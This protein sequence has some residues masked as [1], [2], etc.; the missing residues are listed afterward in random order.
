MPRKE[1]TSLGRVQ[2]QSTDNSANLVT[3]ARPTRMPVPQRS[4]TP[5]VDQDIV[6][7]QQG[8]GGL[9]DALSRMAASQL[10]KQNKEDYRRGQRDRLAA[11]D[12]ILN[13][14]ETAAGSQTEPYRQGFMFQHGLARSIE[15]GLKLEE[16]YNELSAEG[17][18]TPGQFNKFMQTFMGQALEGADDDY[19]IQGYMDHMIKKEAELRGRHAEDNYT[20]SRLTAL[21]DFNMSLRGTLNSGLS[22]GGSP[23]DIHDTVRSFYDHARV[24]GIPLG[25]VDEMA[26]ESLR[27]LAISHGRTDIFGTSAD[28]MGVFEFET[29]DVDNPDKKMTPLA[30]RTQWQKRIFDAQKQV[31]TALKTKTGKVNQM[32][33]LRE[34][35]SIDAAIEAGDYE[36]AS[37]M[38]VGGVENGLWQADKGHSLLEKVEKMQA[39][40]EMKALIRASVANESLHVAMSI[41]PDITDAKVVEAMDEDF[42]KSFTDAM[43]ANDSVAVQDAISTH[44]QMRATQ[45][46]PFKPAFTQI[47]NASPSNLEGWLTAKSNYDQYKSEF[48]DYARANIDKSKQQQFDMFDWSVKEAGMSPEVAAARL[49]E[50][51]TVE[52]R[53]QMNDF[54]GRHRRTHEA[55][56]EDE[57]IAGAHA[58]WWGR[59]K[60]ATNAVEIKRI[61]TDYAIN[62]LAM[63]GGMSSVDA[64][65]EKAE[66]YVDANYKTVK[67]PGTD[68]YDLQPQNGYPFPEDYQEMVNWASSQLAEKLKGTQYESVGYYFQ[69]D[70]N[71]R[72]RLIARDSE[73]GYGVYDQ[74][75]QPITMERSALRS[76]YYTSQLPTEDQVQLGRLTERKLQTQPTESGLVPGVRTDSKTTRAQAH[77]D[78]IDAIAQHN[79]PK[80]KR[81][82]KRNKGNAL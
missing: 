62:H 57:L 26:F 74:T 44:M 47:N 42:T 30:S 77:R 78:A 48:P 54:F 17:L 51:D 13:D 29:L 43:K 22:A 9:T 49:A 39:E 63:S 2:V 60:D 82:R 65:M 19:F 61:V 71:N 24:V 11:T 79:K 3:P 32:A 56:I 55:R 69:P 59:N 70:P 81:S 6:N 76:G 25:Q 50:L 66:A 1:S 67:R 64:A 4:Y 10:Q 37:M 58:P 40:A 8:L 45:G 68:L 80:R 7:I 14:I 52:G 53:Q 36:A 16:A 12:V 23:Q 18:P 34:L 28:D 38:S 41:N 73:T 20:A 72:E 27:E 46:I 15:D 31:N 35:R 5:R 33:K 21:D 75:G